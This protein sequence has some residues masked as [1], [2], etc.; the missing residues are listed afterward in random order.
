MVKDERQEAMK[1]IEALKAEAETALREAQAIAN[2]HNIIF[3]WDW[4]Y[5]MGGSYHPDEGWISSSE[6]C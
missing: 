3:S 4:S 2:E 6:Q 5:G 1:R